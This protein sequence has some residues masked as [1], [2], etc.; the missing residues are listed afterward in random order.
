MDCYPLGL[1]VRVTGSPAIVRNMEVRKRVESIQVRC[2]GC[3]HYSL[4]VSCRTLE[5]WVDWSEHEAGGTACMERL[6]ESLRE[7]LHAMC[8]RQGLA[9]EETHLGEK[10]GQK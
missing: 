1:R 2:V 7:S 10:E 3:S 9:F 6:P 5:S 4:D 8:K